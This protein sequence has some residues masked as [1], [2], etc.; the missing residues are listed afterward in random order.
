MSY[1]GQTSATGNNGQQAPATSDLV[2]FNNN[3]AGTQQVSQNTPLPTQDQAVAAAQTTDGS[4]SVFISGDPNGDF[5]GVN[6][7]E[8]VVTDGTGLAINTRT[9]NPVKTDANNATVLSDMIGGAVSQ[10][11]NDALLIDT[12]GYQS[13]C[14][15][16]ST[17]YLGGI[18]AGNDINGTFGTVGG[19]SLGNANG[20]NSLGANATL[21]FPCVAR[22]IKITCTSAGSFVYYLKQTPMN[23][24]LQNPNIAQIGSVGVV[25]G[26]VGGSLAV[27][28]ASAI[29][30]APT[31]NPLLAGGVD[32][33]GLTRRL[34]TDTTGTLQTNASGVTNQYVGTAI[35]PEQYKPLRVEQIHSDRGQDSL[36][37]LLQQ[38][39]VELK[40]LNYY[41]REIPNSINLMLQQS[42]IYSATLGSMAD[43][44]E[45]F[46][47]D[48]TLFNLTKGQ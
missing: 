5:A 36:Q 25:S 13:I 14:V 17:S 47:S 7:L 29:G 33:G 24:A 18:T 32:S 38:I 16:T 19:I 1:I 48:T 11:L 28:S 43:E 2:G 22:Y 44:Q 45:Q 42:S 26:G 23:F 12:T 40:T 15:T 8:Q 41:T 30:V 46:F 10:K 35:Y 39:L 34:L 31:S 6:I 37:D 9:Q 3:Q 4:L 27:G 20:I 21:I